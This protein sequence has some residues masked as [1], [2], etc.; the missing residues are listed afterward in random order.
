MDL[1]LIL[2]DFLIPFVSVLVGSGV[3]VWIHRVAGERKKAEDRLLN[4]NYL[5]KSTDKLCNSVSEILMKFDVNDSDSRESVR[6]FL[7]EDL[8]DYQRESTFFSNYIDEEIYNQTVSLIERLVK[9]SEEIRE[10]NKDAEEYFSRIKIFLEQ[11]NDEG[12]KLIDLCTQKRSNYNIEFG[13]KYIK[14]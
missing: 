5:L 13:K 6:I 3:T 12:Y 2:K 14:R 11:V 8:F 10:Y 1:L 4:L 9:H 7:T